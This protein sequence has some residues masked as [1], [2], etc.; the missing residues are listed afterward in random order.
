MTDEDNTTSK[1]SKPPVRKASTGAWWKSIGS[2]KKK[3]AQAAAPASP[4]PAPEQATA[5]PPPV[6]SS[7]DTPAAAASAAAQP[8]AERRPQAQEKGEPGAPPSQQHDS[9]PANT[10]ARTGNA[11]RKTTTEPAAKPSAA[12][13]TDPAPDHS[14][15]AAPPSDEAAAPQG[16]SL[17][18]TTPKAAT[19]AAT[20]ATPPPS[21]KTAEPVEEAITVEPSNLSSEDRELVVT[22]TPTVEAKAEKAPP[23][24]GRGRQRAKAKQ[25]P[26]QQEASPTE[27][28]AAQDTGSQEKAAPSKRSGR[29]GGRKNERKKRGNDTAAAKQGAEREQEQESPPGK[30]V[31]SKLLINAEEPEECRIALVEDGRLESFHVNTVSRERTKNNIYKGTIVSIEPNLQVAFVD[32]GTGRNGFLPFSEIHP[33]YYRQDVSEQNRKLIAQQHW[34]KLKIE[35][36]VKK[37]QE[38]L[39]Q[40]VKEVTGNKGANITTYLSLPGRFLVLMPGSDSAGISRK[41]TGE[42]RRSD[43]RQMM[44]D[45]KIPEG[46]GYII[47]T[48]SAEITKRSFQRDLRYLLSLWDDI[49]SK[50]QTRNAPALVYEDQDTIT[51]FLRDHFTPDIQE[52]MVDTDQSYERV[53]N[54]IQLLPAKQRQVRIKMHRGAKPIF[55]Q[56]NIEEQI[57]S[58]FKPQVP[59][60]SGGSIVIDPT[61]ALVAIDVNSGRTSKNAD[62]DDTIFLA[63]IEA[64]AELAR[65]LRLRDLGGL[66]VVD[67]IDM[68]NKKHIREVERQIKTSMKRDK[69]KID[70]SKISRFGLMQISRQKMGAPIEKGSYRTCSHC[71]GRG[72]VRSV[73]TLALYYLRRIQTGI[74]R[75]KVERMQCKL[76]LE[77][78]QYLL[79]KKRAELS[80]LEQRHNATIEIL[81]QVDM[82]PGDNQ[83]EYLKNL[84]ESNGVN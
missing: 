5:T 30:T 2:S 10:A 73:E 43:L 28:E 52:I 34:K 45:F 36:V 14:P 41:I 79:N 39:V 3:K 46:I 38:V 7:E 83:I 78:A 16:S 69:A 75:K 82:A 26:E 48:A 40:V 9:D 53:D 63:N 44:D 76:P 62:F 4:E 60:P 50:G 25:Q 70:T 74:S 33:E 65:Q 47:R 55:N 35:D 77:V 13:T 11:G 64:A 17:A 42:E 21:Q 67:F 56:H 54:F 72:V 37:G 32:M 84:P 59:L 6:S 81:P 23:K 61:E 31:T 57:E 19:Q 68:R 1:N 66:I 18:E 22:E 12:P 71:Q 8:Q 80:D 29:G 49:K 27:G 20:P 58:I 15:A 51:R 24:R